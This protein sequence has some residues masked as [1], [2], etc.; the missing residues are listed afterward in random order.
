MVAG[1]IN[2]EIYDKWFTFENKDQSATRSRHGQ[3]TA[4]YQTLSK[5]SFDID[6]FIQSFVTFYNQTFLQD[7]RNNNRNFKRYEIKNVY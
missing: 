7:R 4:T 3:S 2:D 5:D 1:R 6:V